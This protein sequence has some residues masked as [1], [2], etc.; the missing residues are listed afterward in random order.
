MKSDDTKN[1]SLLQLGLILM[2]IGVIFTGLFLILISTEKKN[3]QTKKG[4]VVVAE[5]IPSMYFDKVNGVLCYSHN[6][7]AISCVKVEKH[8][9]GGEK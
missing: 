4:E 6:G 8:I 1:I 5:E 7:N 2:I 3:I 9:V